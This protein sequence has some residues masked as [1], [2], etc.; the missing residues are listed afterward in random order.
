MSRSLCSGV[1]AWMGAKSYRVGMCSAL[2]F[3]S[4]CGN[5]RLAGLSGLVGLFTRRLSSSNSRVKSSSPQASDFIY[6]FAVFSAYHT[7]RG[8]R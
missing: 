8:R 3:L 4:G 1:E 5:P 2:G 7:A 6:S